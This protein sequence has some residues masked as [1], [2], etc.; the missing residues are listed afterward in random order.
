MLAGETLRVCRLRAHAWRADADNALSA[1]QG[2]LSCWLLMLC[3]PL[4]SAG[5]NDD[6]GLLGAWRPLARALIRLRACAQSF[7]HVPCTVPAISAHQPSELPSDRR[8]NPTSN[9]ALKPHSSNQ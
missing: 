4:V 5:D 1:E 6:G 3:R 7:H 2:Q 8:R 9:H